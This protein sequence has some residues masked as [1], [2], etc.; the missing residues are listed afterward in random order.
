[1][2]ELAKLAQ[3]RDA[4]LL[5]EIGAWLHMLGKY[6][7]Q[8][9]E[10]HCNG[11][12]SYDYQNFIST[13]ATQYP[14]LFG[15][16]DLDS[17]KY[18][19]L[20]ST[21]P[22]TSPP[23]VGVFIRDHRKV[24]KARQNNLCDQLTMLLVDAHGRGSNI[25]KSEIKIK[26]PNQ[27]LPHIYL[28][29]AFGFSQQLAISDYET[30]VLQQELDE[31]VQNLST[32][33]ASDKWVTLC[34]EIRQKTIFYIQNSLAETRLPFNDVTLFDQTASTV[35]FF[36]AALAEIIVAGKWKKLVEN[37]VNQY[38]WRTLTIPFMGL[39]YLH[40]VLGIPDLLG[41]Q[42][43]LANA[44]N[45]VQNLLEITYPI[46]QEI[47]RDA[48]CSLFLVPDEDN[49]L[50]WQ[51]L[52]GQNLG[53]L[54]QKEI[55]EATSGDMFPDLQR[56]LMAQGTR[57]LYTIGQQINVA[58][59]M[60]VTPDVDTATRVWQDVINQQICSNCSLRPQGPSNKASKRRI[61]D[62]CLARREERSK[63]WVTKQFNSTVWLDEITDSNGRLALITGSWN[64]TE[65]LNGTLVN[66]IIAASDVNF[67]K[68]EQDCCKSLQKNKKG[69]PQQFQDLLTKLLNKDVRQQFNNLFRG[70]FETIIQPEWQHSSV[71]NLPEKTIAAMHFVRQNPSFARLRRIWQ[72][73]QTFWQTA[74]NGQDAKGYPILPTVDHRLEIVPHNR[75]GLDLGHYHTYDLK[76]TNNVTLS[77]VWDSD[78]K[79]F[80]TCDNL[81][82]LA[83]PERLGRPVIECL[84]GELM[85]EEPSSYGRKNKI[86]ATIRIEQAGKIPDSA[87]TATIPILAEPRTFMTL[88]PADRA[89]DMVQAIKTKYER[90]MGKVRNRLPLHVGVVYAGRRTPLR[91][92]LDAGRRMLNYEAKGAED[93]QWTVRADA[94]QGRLP[95][96]Q[97]ALAEG[98]QQ[99]A[100]T[101]MV[102][103]KQD[104]RS[105]TWYVPAVMGD[106]VTP[107]NWYPYLFID[108]DVT[109]RDCTFKAMRPT[110]ENQ[111]EERNLIHARQLKAGDEVYFTPATFDFQWLDRAGRRFELAYD[112]SGRRR[113]HLNRPYLLDDLGTIQ[114]GWQLV[115]DKTGLTNSQI[116]ALRDLVE[117]KRD[118]WQPTPE[119]CQL[120]GMF[121]KFCRD[122]IVNAN[123]KQT[124]T[125]AQLEQ[126]TDWAVS[127][128]LTDII[129]LYMSIMK[130]KPQREEE[131]NE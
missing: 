57:T 53:D 107:D 31:L 32:S 92:I 39:N 78:N 62:L 119:Q 9:I 91:A 83:K 72:T 129:E 56:S 104:C 51:N 68:L 110:K 61:C 115:S 35:A 127:G 125:K 11:T 21:L 105:L 120:G 79:R 89:L 90:E 116:Y 60:A 36:K 49:L 13:F 16:L 123:W 126:L 4:I 112:D 87:Y 118:S 14:E 114:Q 102:Q 94:E 131:N 28:S 15:L 17:S 121:W 8:F 111:M 12:S 70:Y 67:K 82:Y 22:I 86:K 74:L 96:E 113:G 50:N 5:A 65:W 103:L 84:Q 37:R 54:I 124:P 97:E 66:T 44:Q 7:W 38:K 80:I 122:A 6:D 59:S 98:T 76:L 77:V 69:N 109:N 24:Q 3:H 58:V 55:I 48:Q 128:L 95:H 64:L 26:F 20:L 41:R 81:A 25:E 27:K 100:E 130:Q 40:A 106:G 101:I 45:S 63:E 85:L 2:S 108:N 88:V 52:D 75:D 33:T 19:I 47:Y 42:N 23:N 29:T 30:N 34:Q 1:M 43:I 46:G 117:S 10:K 18:Q 93:K 71:V 73:T 99:F